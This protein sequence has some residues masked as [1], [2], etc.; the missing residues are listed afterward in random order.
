MESLGITSCATKGS[1]RAVESIKNVINK[2]PRST[3][4]VRSTLSDFLVEYFFDSG[5]LPSCIGAIISFYL[6]HKK[7]EIA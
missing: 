5:R 1:E 4:G 3:I 2:K 7:E 6:R